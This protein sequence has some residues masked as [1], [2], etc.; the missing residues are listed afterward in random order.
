MLTIRNEQMKV[1]EESVTS[2]FKGEMVQHLHQFVPRHCAVIGMASVEQVVDR[3]IATAR[4]HGFTNRGPVR[5]YLELMSMFGSG[6]ATDPVLPWAVAPLA[7]SD[8]SSQMDR[9]EQLHAAVL[10]YLEQVAG[11]N[12]QLTIIALRRLSSIDAAAL[13]GA[14]GSIEDRLIGAYRVLYPQKAAY[15]G[16]SRLRLL[17]DL[18]KAKAERFSITTERGLALLGALAF[19]IGHEATDD[20]LFPWISRTL[21]DEALGS[22]DERASRL[23]DRAM[24]YLTR[25]LAHLERKQ[26]DVPS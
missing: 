14:T 22:P 2:A 8:E 23:H 6:F 15:A 16:D 1:F 17:I 11:A 5:L 24:T 25:A 12:N 18:A 3:G 26:S 10:G 21:H 7:A 9:A 13:L 4:T 19:A 20:P